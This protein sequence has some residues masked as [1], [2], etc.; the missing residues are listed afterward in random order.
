MVEA[1]NGVNPGDWGRDPQILKWVTARLGLDRE[2][3]GSR[4]VRPPVFKTD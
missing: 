1:G 2:R 3:N 4:K